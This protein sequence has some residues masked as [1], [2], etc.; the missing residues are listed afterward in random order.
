MKL[1]AITSYTNYGDLVHI[2]KAE[3]E[4]EAIIMAKE[5]GA[6]DDFD[7]NELNYDIEKGV[8]YNSF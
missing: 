7:I 3:S 1:Y 5:D 2:V 6:W 8:L 4:K